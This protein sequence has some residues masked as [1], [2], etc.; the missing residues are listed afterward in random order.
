[1]ELAAFTCRAAMATHSVFPTSITHMTG[2][3]GHCPAHLH[4]RK[5]RQLLHGSAMQTSVHHILMSAALNTS[6][7]AVHLPALFSLI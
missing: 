5:S 7:A 1:M 2:C 6:L 3:R 4:D